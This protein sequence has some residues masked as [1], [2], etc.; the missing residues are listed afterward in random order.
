MMR[1]LRE[2]WHRFWFDAEAP[3][4]LGLSRALF[5]GLI[6]LLYLNESWSEWSDVSVVFWEPITMFKWLRIP[7]FSGGVLTLLS[8]VW[9]AS[10]LTAA[11]GLFT[12]GSAVV[13]CAI[14]W[15]LLGLPH[16]FGKTHHFDALIV[17]ILGVL[18]LARTD[19]AF[20]LDQ[21]LF[22]H[23]RSPKPNGEYRWPVR[24]A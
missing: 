1:A 11:L 14:G 22:G 17:L 5:Y 20:S 15:Y 23:D 12:R 24:A 7:V 10:L 9:K 13:A 8:V 6:L 3:D 19:D 18:T 2:R 21:R 4:N 16:N